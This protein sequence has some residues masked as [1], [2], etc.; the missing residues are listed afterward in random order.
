MSYNGWQGAPVQ[1]GNRLNH[2]KDNAARL[3][4]LLSLFT[5]NFV[6]A[7]AQGAGVVS[8]IGRAEKVLFGNESANLPVA[9]RMD[10]LDLGIFGKRQ[11]GSLASR[12]KKVEAVL[13]LEE[14]TAR[15]QPSLQRLKAQAPATAPERFDG[16]AHASLGP[17]AATGALP[18][19]APRSVLNT[20]QL[21]QLGSLKFK[22]GQ[23]AQAEAAFRQALVQDP[24]NADALFNLAAL[25]E[26]RGDYVAAFNLDKMALAI[27]PQDGELK[28]ALASVQEQLARARPQP[29]PPLFGQADVNQTAS[30]PQLFKRQPV[31]AAAPLQ[32]SVSSNTSVQIGTPPI[33]QVTNPPPA[34]LAVAPPPSGSANVRHAMLPVIH[35]G[36]SALPLPGPLHGLSCP[37]CKLLG[38]Y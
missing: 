10:A 26:W 38:S 2:S 32:G 22:A 31:F 23:T 5:F 29:A 9:K 3:L 20:K 14:G 6:P 28:Q 19:L 37:L 30:P 13:Q 16:K 25:C 17:L 35:A 11:K 36:F 27:K 24:N 34:T 4:M 12:L 1:T 8:S 15:S 18:P 7:L 21:L 33:L